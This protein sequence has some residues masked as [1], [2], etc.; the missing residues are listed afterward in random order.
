M[1]NFW[2]YWITGLIAGCSVLAGFIL[3]MFITMLN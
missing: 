2:N 3:L 1:D